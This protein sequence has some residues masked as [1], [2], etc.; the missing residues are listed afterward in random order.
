M[1]SR[2]HFSTEKI[3]GGGLVGRWGGL[4]SEQT[5]RLVYG[6]SKYLRGLDWLKKYTGGHSPVQLDFLWGETAQ[7]KEGQVCAELL[8][9]RPF[10]CLT[11]AWFH[12]VCREPELSGLQVLEDLGSQNGLVG[13]FQSWSL[14][15]LGSCISILL[16]LIPLY[17]ISHNICLELRGKNGSGSHWVSGKAGIE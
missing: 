17:T 13:S 10:P 11:W 7:Q 5:G 16:C 2:R 12:S 8:T 6:F 15:V 14:V 4:I 1:K 9:Y 3:G